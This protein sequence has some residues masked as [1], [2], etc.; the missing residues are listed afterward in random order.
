MSDWKPFGMAG[1]WDFW[2]GP[3]GLIRSCTIVTTTPN[4]MTANVHDRMPVIL[5][6]EAQGEWLARDNQDIEALSRLLVTYQADS[7][8][9]YQISP[10]IGAVN[11]DSKSL[12][13]PV[14]QA[15][16]L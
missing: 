8:A 3:R 13:N 5:S 2:Q 16:L 4:K 10:A 12:L 14:S 6:R 15:M 11:N 9:M 1:L 7:M